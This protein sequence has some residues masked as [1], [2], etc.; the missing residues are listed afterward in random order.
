MTIG[1]VDDVDF[2]RTSSWP[3]CP[4][5]AEPNRCRKGT[6][7]RGPSAA[8][9]IG[10][11]SS[12]ALLYLRCNAAVV[13]VPR[14]ER[15]QVCVLARPVTRLASAGFFHRRQDMFR[16]SV[17]TRSEDPVDQR[18]RGTETMQ[19]LC[20]A[21]A[22][23]GRTATRVRRPANC[24]RLWVLLTQS[25]VSA[26]A[27]EFSSMDTH[28]SYQYRSAAGRHPLRMRPRVSA[29]SPG[30]HSSKHFG[31]SALVPTSLFEQMPAPASI[32]LQC[33][34]AHVPG[35]EDSPPK[36]RQQTGT[37]RRRPFWRAPYMVAE[38]II[39]GCDV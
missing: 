36:L 6:A 16:S 1:R 22:D 27:R 19:R 9:A 2:L 34:R 29:L 23:Q 33:R 17:P 13:R 26:K 11:A 7:F 38:S 14:L 39:N 12:C 37:G 25:Q 15:L 24:G 31:P 8:R 20:R 18:P 35:P 5:R 10:V 3:S 21:L 32:R 4:R 28:P 30:C